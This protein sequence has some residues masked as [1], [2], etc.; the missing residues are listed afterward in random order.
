MQDTAPRRKRSRSARGE[1][2]EARPVDYR[3]LVSPLPLAQGYSDDQIESIHQGAL[4]VLQELG[5]RVIHDKAREMFAEAGA[6]VRDMQVHLPPEMVEGAI[7][8]SPA[9]FT[10]TSPRG[11]LNIGGRNTQFIPVGGPPHATDIKRGKRPG[12]FEDFRNFIRL[13]QSHEVI[14]LT[15][16]SVE[17]QDIPPNLRHL[18]M[19][20]VQTLDSDKATFIYARGAGQ[21]ADSLQMLKLRLGLDDA[22]FQER[23][24]TYTVINTNSP[25]ILDDPMCQGLI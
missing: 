3:N 20:R 23:P 19:M 18:R 2:K 8:S 11:T 9:E 12:T 24:Y 17:P 13:A 22:A 16:P 5:V 1:A 25:L 4:T 10:L 14:H 6:D 21:T 7:A 15:G